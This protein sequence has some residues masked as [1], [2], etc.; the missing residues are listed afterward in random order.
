MDTPIL[1]ALQTGALIALTIS[2]GTDALARRD[3]MMGWLSATCLL[4]GLR[5]GVL[6]LGPGPMIDLDFIERTQSLLVSLGFV[7][8][9]VALIHLFPRHLPRRFPLWILLGMTPNFFRN[10]ALPY[11]H[12]LDAP[13]HHF[14]NVVYLVGCGFIIRSALKARH[15]G[16]PMGERLFLGLIGVT[17]PVVIEIAAMSFFDLKVRLSGFSMVILGMAIGTSWHWLVAQTQQ[18]R[19]R[20]AELEA[21]AW[22]ALL[23]G[24]TFHTDRPS[25]LMEAAFGPDW[26]TRLR[27]QEVDHLTGQDGTPYRLHFRVLATGHRLGWYE[28]EEETRTGPGGFLS[29]WTVAIGVDNPEE[30]ARIQAWLRLWGAEVDLW[31][32]VPPREGP[33]PS[34]LVW[35]RE[36]SILSVWREDDLLRR[37]PRWIQVGGPHTDGPHVRLDPPLDEGSLRTAL[38]GLISQ[39]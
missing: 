10:L 39:H 27:E 18:T 33:Y 3:R 30:A 26:T 34:V 21:G 1:D 8:L 28:R 37:R 29:G 13:L 7:A 22:A 15:E 2:Y 20:N 6:A 19:V 12:P 24:V 38:Q 35:A 16:D 17:L 23:P 11:A 25:P 14:V 31:G 36:P 4:V 5:H 32:M 9:C